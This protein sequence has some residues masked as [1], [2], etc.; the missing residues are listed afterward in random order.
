MH[1][2]TGDLLSLGSDLFVDQTF[3][4]SL[5]LNHR[6]E[7]IRFSSNRLDLKISFVNQNDSGLY[8]CM[9]D[10]HQLSS[11]LLEVFSK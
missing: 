5:T 3:S 6:L 8:T 4:S 7:L 11:Y 2:T 10:D 1:Q 9:F